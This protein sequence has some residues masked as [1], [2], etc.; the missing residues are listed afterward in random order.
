VSV[1]APHQSDAVPAQAVVQSADKLTSVQSL[2]KQIIH[3]ER[4]EHG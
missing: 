3:R 2:I 1:Q 4:A